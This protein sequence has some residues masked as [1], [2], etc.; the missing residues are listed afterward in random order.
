[1][2]LYLNFNSLQSTVLPRIEAHGLSEEALLLIEVPMFF[3]T[4][5]GEGPYSRGG[6]ESRKYGSLSPFISLHLVWLTFLPKGVFCY[7]KHYSPLVFVSSYFL[8]H[9]W[10][11]R[12]KAFYKQHYANTN[13]KNTR[14]S[15]KRYKTFKFCKGTKE[16]KPRVT[17]KYCSAATV[18]K[19][20]HGT[21]TKKART[22][23]V[24]N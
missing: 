16:K 7:F 4:T 21:N 10:Q 2:I 19:F 6:A 23:L 17:K 12:T 5:S 15:E 13:V 14:S 8:V 9:F 22:W 11:S 20:F 1:M 18:S 3:Q 24:L